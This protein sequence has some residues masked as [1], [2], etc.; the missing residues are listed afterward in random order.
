MAAC[1][2]IYQ[3][4]LDSSKER[5]HKCQEALSL[6]DTKVSTLKAEFA[7]KTAEAESLKASLKKAEEVISI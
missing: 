4:E 2:S 3:A 7:N 1:V 6:L 5:L